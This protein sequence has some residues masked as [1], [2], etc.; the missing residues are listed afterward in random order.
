VTQT[1]AWIVRDRRPLSAELEAFLAAGEPPIYFGFGSAHTAQE[2]SRAA[3]DAARALGRRAIVLS[4]WAG[5]A[6]IDN[7]SDCLS[8]TEENLQALFP[9]VTAIVHHGGAGTTTL[10]ALAGTP[11]VVVPR[12]YDQHYFA[13]RVDQLGIGSAHSPTTPT[14]DSL[15]AALT[16]ALEREVAVR[17]KSFA[18]YI[19][20]DGTKVAVEHIARFLKKNG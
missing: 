14:A 9:R 12:G 5:L 15:I 10:A 6:L 20:T 16:S 8:I 4:G 17:A 2:T 11:Q 7:A 19:R 1:G 3:I 18:G 13:D